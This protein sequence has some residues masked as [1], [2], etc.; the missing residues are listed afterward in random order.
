MITILGLP[1]PVIS[2]ALPS[3]YTNP[4]RSS[5][6]KD[7]FS[8]RFGNADGVVL[9]ASVI[10]PIKNPNDFSNKAGGTDKLKLEFEK[11]YPFYNPSTQSPSKNKVIVIDTL[12][13]DIQPD[14]GQH[15]SMAPT[16]HHQIA[17]S[18]IA[19]WQGNIHPD[20]HM[21]VDRAYHHDFIRR[22]ERQELEGIDPNT[23]NPAEKEKLAHY[24]ERSA[25]ALLDDINEQ[26]DFIIKAKT[27]GIAIKIPNQD[28][29]NRRLQKIALGRHPR[30][31][32]AEIIAEEKPSNPNMA[33]VNAYINDVNIRPLEMMHRLY[34]D[35]LNTPTEPYYQ[36]LRL[37]SASIGRQ[38]VDVY[39]DILNLFYGDNKDL[40]PKQIKHVINL[41][42]T[43]LANGS[44]LDTSIK[45][46]QHVTKKLTNND[47]LM[48]IPTGNDEH[49][50]EQTYKMKQF[51]KQGHGFAYYGYSDDVVSVAGSDRNDGS[52]KNR[53]YTMLDK[54]DQHRMADFSCSSFK[55]ARFKPTLTVT[56]TNVL[57]GV[58]GYSGGTSLAV[59]GA[60]GVAY[61]VLKNNPSQTATQLINNLKA[62][63]VRIPK[64]G[65]EF[66][67]A[68][69]LNPNAV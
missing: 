41:V 62:A 45:E 56:A 16:G 15:H 6:P 9:P 25:T 36:D 43:T 51:D 10:R 18:N 54:F 7:T 27:Q 48:F 31:I 17:C 3:T 60:V 34:K 64:V 24:I 55:D 11:S 44:K 12:K 58:S 28:T 40:T 23:T 2:D 50:F 65:D 20:D 8:L 59:P 26:L 49:F 29:F 14:R 35:L 67:G 39:R 47:I 69:V 30:Y 32:A 61:R 13:S 66:Q 42:D 33:V 53:N 68:G 19:Q 21:A 1:V 4:I 5:V 63:C 57:D 38:G 37:I 46:Y 22:T 52:P